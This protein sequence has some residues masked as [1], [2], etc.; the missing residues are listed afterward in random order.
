MRLPFILVAQ[1]IFHVV[2]FEQ[3]HTTSIILNNQPIVL[4][5]SQ[6]FHSKILAEN[7]KVNIYLPPGYSEKDTLKYPV[8]YL[9]DGGIDEDFIHTVGLVQF[10][11]FSWVNR[12]PE[13]IV[14]GIVNV[15][16]RRDFTYP[17]SIKKDIESYPTTGHS[18]TFISFIE[19][20]LQPFINSQFKTSSSKTIIGQSLG[21]LLACE[22]LLHKPNLFDHYI[23]ISPSLWWDDGSLLRQSM[24]LPSN[25]YKEISIYI[26]VGK[27]GLTPGDA[28]HI[29][30][31]DANLFAEKIKQL[32]NPLLHTQFD[33]LSAEDHAT[34]GHQAIYN[35]FRW[36]Y[37][38]GK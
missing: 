13:S 1:I 35:A 14:V 4:G 21:G 37:A 3:E 5:N 11:N 25:I 33:Y 15:D 2:S 8:I 7:R 10:D 30:E 16:R 20:E 24:K 6:E 19:Q 32:K 22:I 27:E 12:L 31:A 17:T 36:M 29:M 28:P 23:I 26:V 18:E 34:I 9:L 38:K